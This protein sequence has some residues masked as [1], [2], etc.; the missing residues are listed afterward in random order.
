MQMVPFLLEPSTYAPPTFLWTMYIL[1]RRGRRTI[2]S[3][4]STL[5]VLQDQLII[6]CIHKC[7]YITLY[8]VLILFPY[9]TMLSHSA[10]CPRALYQHYAYNIMH[11]HISYYDK[12]ITAH[13]YTGNIRHHHSDNCTCACGTHA[14][15]ALTTRDIIILLW[16]HMHNIPHVEK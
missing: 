10:T 12:S 3:D 13:I 7:K 5:A 2:D 11:I 1:C 9:C 15:R 16:M 8:S 14:I 4:Y 6:L